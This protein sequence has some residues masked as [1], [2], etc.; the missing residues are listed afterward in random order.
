[1]DGTNVIKIRATRNARIK[2]TTF[3]LISIMG[4]PF[5]EL[6]TNR[7]RPK[8]GEARPT[9]RLHT[10]I[11][12]RWTGS[13]P[14]CWAIGISSG[15]RIRMAGAPSINIPKIRS[16]IL[17]KIRKEMRLEIIPERKEAKTCG[18]L[19]MVRIRLKAVARAS[20]A[21]RGAQAWTDSSIRVHSCFREMVR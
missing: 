18:A 17:S 2:G 21:Q 11:M 12:P 3:R 10:M 1:M 15:E 7:F 9:A 8:G 4:A 14:N 20:N 13:I 5:V 6:A 16:T 19:S